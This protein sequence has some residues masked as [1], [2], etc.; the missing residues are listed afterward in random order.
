MSN[1]K[2]LIVHGFF[3]YVY[4]MWFLDLLYN[5]Y[6]FLHGI[7]LPAHFSTYRVDKPEVSRSYPCRCPWRWTRECVCLSPVKQTGHLK[8]PPMP[9]KLCSIRWQSS[10]A[11][12]SNIWLHSLHSWLMPSSA[13]RRQT[14]MYRLDQARRKK[15]EHMTSPQ[16][17]NTTLITDA[18]TEAV[19]VRQQHVNPLNVYREKL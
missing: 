19:A 5:P 12:E 11:G 6:V 10:L 8:V 14:R 2:F 18:Y 3:L 4:R 13:N 15:Q 7:Y 9:S 17:I 16:N 1:D